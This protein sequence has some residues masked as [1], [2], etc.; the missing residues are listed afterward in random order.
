MCI[1]MYS[2][3]ILTIEQRHVFLCNIC[4][5]LYVGFECPIFPIMHQ[6][7]IASARQPLAVLSIAK[8]ENCDSGAA[9]MKLQS[10]FT[11]Q[12]GKAANGYVSMKAASVLAPYNLLLISHC[13]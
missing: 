1:H 4:T 6:K 11:E 5:T 2:T 12:H 3:V 10:A 9:T 8:C 7:N 13:A